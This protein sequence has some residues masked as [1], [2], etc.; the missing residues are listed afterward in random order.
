MKSKA[1][2]IFGL[3]HKKI[4]GISLLSLLFR[5]GIGAVAFAM[6]TVNWSPSTGVRITSNQ[7]GNQ[8]VPKIIQSGNDFIL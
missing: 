8:G 5:L 4:L 7:P 6:V 2:G 1:K 3:R